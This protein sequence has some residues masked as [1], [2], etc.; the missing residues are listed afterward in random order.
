MHKVKYNLSHETRNPILTT[1]GPLVF[2]KVEV[3]TYDFLSYMISRL[4]HQKKSY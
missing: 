3:A 1:H 2:Y 4:M